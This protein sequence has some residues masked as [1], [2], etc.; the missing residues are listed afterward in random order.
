MFYLVYVSVATKPFTSSEL[1]E[2]L[3]KSR[4]NNSKLGITGMLLYRY[5]DFIQILEGEES[6]VRQVYAKILKDS[7]HE[8][9]VVVD[10]GTMPVRQFEDWSMG[11]KNLT[12]SDIQSIEGFNQLMNMRLTSQDFKSAPSLCWELLIT[13]KG[14]S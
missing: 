6:V 1:T 4:E 5:P 8:G 10:E 2:I 7:R 12:D 3:A 9:G 13:F 14:Y 11:F